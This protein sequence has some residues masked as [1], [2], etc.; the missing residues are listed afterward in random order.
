MPC[1]SP[2]KAYKEW[3]PEEAKYK[4]TIIGQADD[5]I[6]RLKTPRGEFFEIPCGHCIGCR[7]DYAKEWANRCMLEAK[8]YKHNEMLTLTYNE[9]NLPVTKTEKTHEGIVEHATLVKKDV[10][11]F[12]KRLR[13]T[14]KRKYNWENI[15]FYMCGEYGELNGRPHYHLIMFN[16]PVF[17]KEYLNTN[18][19]GYEQ[20]TSKEI[21]AIW[22]KGRIALS[23]VNWETCS[24]V[25]RYIMKKQKGPGSKEYYE[26]KGQIPEYVCMSRN[27][28]IARN[29]YEQKKDTIYLTD[30]I[31]IP[32]KNGIQKVR[33]NRYF[34]KLYDIEEPGIMSDIKRKREA[35]A[36][37][38][39]KNEIN[40][41]DLKKTMYLK[42]KEANKKAQ[43]RT[44]KR[45][46]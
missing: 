2:L 15:R 31:F 1:F 28:G 4:V 7:L 27:P 5:R 14:W 3:T 40:R 23:P 30:E 10:Q 36:E 29:Y 32:T 39:L 18:K 33:P 13:Q 25:A 24:Y 37:A 44:L 41:T 17:D 43:T 6:E 19:K 35:K 26:E 46:L 8:E 38:S 34:D 9:E 12:L 21:E 45:D 16:L 11:D 42:V 20:M 22:G